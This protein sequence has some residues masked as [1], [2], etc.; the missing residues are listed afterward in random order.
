M[1]KTYVDPMYGDRYVR[2]RKHPDGGYWWHWNDFG[3]M[4]L[5]PGRGTNHPEGPRQG[6]VDRLGLKLV[7]RASRRHGVRPAG[8]LRIPCVDCRQEIDFDWAGQASFLH[9]ACKIKRSPLSAAGAP[10]RSS[11]AK[12]KRLKKQLELF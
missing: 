12:P 9:P 2:G 1:P 7:T 3:F 11:Q 4:Y 6:D 5:R 10:Q 8:V